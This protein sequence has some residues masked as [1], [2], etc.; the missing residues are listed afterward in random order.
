MRRNNLDLL[1][2][3]FIAV[4]NVI[5]ASLPNRPVL[6]STILA[7]PMV[8]VLP[9]YTLTEALFYP[10]WL[11]GTHRLVLSLGL[12]LA[13][14]ILGGLLLNML[15]IGLQAQSWALF[16]GLVTI[17]F[18]LVATYFR[19]SV[20]LTGTRRLR[21]RGSISASV[22]LGLATTVAILSVLFSIIGVEQQPHP[23][24]TQFWMLPTVRASTNCA[25]QFGVRSYEG[26]PVTYRVTMTMN[27][28][29]LHR[30][31]PVVL[32]PEQ[33]WN[34]I[35]PVTPGTAHSIYLEARLYRLDQPQSVYRNVHLTLYNASGSTGAKECSTT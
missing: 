28:Q 19:R 29:L 8:F 35:V 6:P 33:T 2:I 13:L 3:A 26:T 20:Q 17:V 9:G 25:V 22:F 31:S 30:W 10:K 16:L 32:K 12:S 4:L 15:P 14:A 27:G 7:L 18:S 34:Q 24:F 11:N 1:V 5:L 21:F 23:G